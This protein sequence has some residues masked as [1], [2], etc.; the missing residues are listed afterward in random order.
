[1]KK[2]AAGAFVMMFFLGASFGKS[3]WRDD[4][5]RLFCDR[6][7]YKVGDIVTVVIS[8]GTSAKKS[9]EVE[10]EK[11]SSVKGGLSTLLFPNIG[12]HKGTAPAWDVSNETK[13]EADSEMTRSDT[14]SGTISCVVV[15]VLP[16]G[17]LLIEGKRVVTL[18]GERQY[19]ILRGI[20]RPRDIRADNTVLSQYVADAE[21][22][23]SGRGEIS[24][25]Q[26]SGILTR[27][28]DWL[29]IF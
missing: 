29:R 28:L 22:E 17:N 4:A 13:S 16:N 8:E 23:Y 11:S 2:I 27:I 15:D 3:L 19:L 26:R 18:N 1:M 14:L 9:A 7:A 24:E 20:V 5:A 10:H 12:K 25:K 21:I 6:K